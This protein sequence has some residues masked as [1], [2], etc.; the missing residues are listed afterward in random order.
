VASITVERIALKAARGVDNT[1]LG[2][3]T[4]WPKTVYYQSQHHGIPYG[5]TVGVGQG[6]AVGLARTGVGLYELV[7]SPVPVPAS[8]RPILSPAFSLQPEETRIAW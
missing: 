4:E 7:T 1:V 6:L 5:A 2:L 8:Y 3:V